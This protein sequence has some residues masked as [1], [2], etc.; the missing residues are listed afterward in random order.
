MIDTIRKIICLALS[1]VLFMSTVL[2]HAALPPRVT[3]LASVTAGLSTPLRIAAD[4][5]G[6]YYLSDPRGGGILKYNQSWNL[7]Q[8][9][10]AS[11]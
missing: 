8:T 7:I 3:N 9:I 2:A 11:P 10:T 4:G 1:S 6:N 5:A